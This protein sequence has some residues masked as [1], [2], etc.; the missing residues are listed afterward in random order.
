MTMPDQGEGGGERFVMTWAQKVC[1]RLLARYRQRRVGTLPRMPM[2]THRARRHR[3]PARHLR[4]P[5]RGQRAVQPRLAADRRAH[6]AA[7]PAASACWPAPRGIGGIAFDDYRLRLPDRHAGAGAH[8]VRRRAQH[9]ARGGAARWAPAGVLATVGVGAH[10]PRLVAVPAHLGG[11]AWPEAL[12]LGAVVSST[13]AAA[14]FAVLRGSGLQLKRRVGRDAR[15]G[16]RHQRSGGGHPH[17]RAH[18]Q[19]AATR[20][21][22]RAGGSR[23]RWWCSSR[24]ARPWGRPSGMAGTLR[25]G[26]AAARDRRS[27]PRVHARARRCSPSGWRR[28]RTAAGSSPCTSPGSCWATGRCP[29]A[30]GC[31]GCTTRW[32]GWPDR[33]VPRP[34]AAGVPVPAARDRAGWDWAWRCSS[35]VVVRPLVV[36]GSVSLPFR[37]PRRRCST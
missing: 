5:A 29:I 21:P 18:P 15:G 28:W 20:A 16:V 12:L 23:W 1:S 37:Y 14:V 11:L 6:R 25:A 34:G 22:S 17:H 35:A 19:P 31:S 30:P 2:L 13:D 10:R 24:W 32:P 36:A 7:L 4:P 8:P 27:L 33:D 3:P 26:A 9:P